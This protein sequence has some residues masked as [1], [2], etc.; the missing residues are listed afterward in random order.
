MSCKSLFVIGALMFAPLRATAA[1]SLPAV[2]P[3]PAAAAIPACEVRPEQAAYT[4]TI[5]N[6]PRAVQKTWVQEC[7]S[8]RSYRAVPDCPPPCGPRTPVC[9]EAARRPCRPCS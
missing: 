3:V 9:A 7:G 1:T 2:P 6:G 5:Y 4:M 8:W